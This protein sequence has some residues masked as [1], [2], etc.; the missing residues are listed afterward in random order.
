MSDSGEDNRPNMNGPLELGPYRISWTG[1]IAP[2]I[3]TLIFISIGLAIASRW[4]VVGTIWIALFLALYVYGFLVR[5]SLKL[6]ADTDGIWVFQGVLPWNKGV[7][8]VKWRDLDEATFRQ[9]FFGW[10]F[11]SYSMRIGHRF[12]KSSEILLSHMDRG[13]EAVI[14]INQ[15]HMDMVR[16]GEIQ[17]V[18]R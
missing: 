7:A 5:R 1:H 6:Y 9:G 4:P 14:E 13:R 11:K 16:R 2:T 17:D 8:G 15:T 10:V 3:F 12:T 18:G